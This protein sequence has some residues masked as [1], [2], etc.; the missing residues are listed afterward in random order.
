MKSSMEIVY[1]ECGIWWVFKEE[2]KKYVKENFIE[3]FI[4]EIE[5]K[6]WIKVVGVFII[7]LFEFLDFDDVLMIESDVFFFMFVVG[8]YIVDVSFFV[9]LNSFLDFEVFFCCIFYYFGDG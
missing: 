7:D 2:I 5:W 6:S 1:V 8:I 4:F 9:K 3:W